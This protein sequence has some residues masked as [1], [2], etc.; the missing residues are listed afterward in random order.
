[1]SAQ[2]KL[3]TAT[4]NTATAPTGTTLIGTQNSLLIA[5]EHN[6]AEIKS[7]FHAGPTQPLGKTKMWFDTNANCM[8]INNG[9]D[10]VAAAKDATKSEDF[11]SF[12]PTLVYTGLVQQFTKVGSETTYDEITPTVKLTRGEDGWLY[13]AAVDSG[14]TSDTPTGTEWAFAGLSGNPSS[15][16]AADYASLT[17]LPFE[18]SVGSWASTS[19]FIP[20][21]CHLIEE[22]IYFD[23]MLAAWFECA[24]YPES[25]MIILQRA[26]I[27]GSSIGEPIPTTTTITVI[28]DG[29]FG[30]TS[31]L[32]IDDVLY[33]PGIHSI[34]PGLHNIRHGGT[35]PADVQF[36]MSN[37]YITV[38]IEDTEIEHESGSKPGFASVD[39]FPIAV[40]TTIKYGFISN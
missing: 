39:T 12:K 18:A 38:G 26:A 34:A 31:E 24:S 36:N 32:Y 20:G 5:N 33:L 11:G 37:I 1:M 13:N 29:D 40:N 8:K 3:A 9:K 17:F 10:W 4:T 6:K 2:I 22:D 25:A 16:S 21:V 14:Y 28:D 19:E 30:V 7:E 23:F 27:P 35:Y 15:I